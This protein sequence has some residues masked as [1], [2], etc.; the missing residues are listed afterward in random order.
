MMFHKISV[1]FMLLICGGC[2]ILRSDR[3]ASS[4]WSV[5]GNRVDFVLPA[6]DATFV[7]GVLTQ[8]W[9]GKDFTQGMQ[10]YHFTKAGPAA[11]DGCWFPGAEKTT[12]TRVTDDKIAVS[13]NGKLFWCERLEKSWYSQEV[14]VPGGGTISAVQFVP[15][16]VNPLV[17]VR[18]GDG[19]IEALLCPLD[20]SVC[21]KVNLTNAESAEVLGIAAQD[22][23]LFVLGYATQS[24]IRNFAFLVDLGRSRTVDDVT[25]ILTRAGLGGS[26]FV[27]VSAGNRSFWVAGKSG[28]S[29]FDPSTHQLEGVVLKNYRGVITTSSIDNSALLIAT[30][31]YR[32][33]RVSGVV[34]NTLS[35]KIHRA[36]QEDLNTQ[37]LANLAP[38]G[39]VTGIATLNHDVVA[40]V[41]VDGEQKIDLHTIGRD[42]FS[43]AQD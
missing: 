38:S 41:E 34:G 10:V 2:S 11:L 6:D 21:Q 36:E 23:W 26:K 7:F 25:G 15:D 4:S 24:S 30:S 17:L 8:K 16:Q 32:N 5:V 42:D 14:T 9:D 12:G 3:P 31:D 40:L 18:A 33:R 20:L 13:A 43:A 28:V 35:T 19:Q 27:A 37:Q 1:C 29:K 39:T 22:G